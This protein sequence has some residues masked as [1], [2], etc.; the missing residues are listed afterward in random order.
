[1]NNN[2]LIA[3]V[4]RLK[5]PLPEIAKELSIP[6][7]TL[8]KF[9]SGKKE[10]GL[11]EFDRVLEWVEHKELVN[12]FEK[13]LQDEYDKNKKWS[14]GQTAENLIIFGQ[15]VTHEPSGITS[16]TLEECMEKVEELSATIDFRPTDKSAYDGDKLNTILDEHPLYF[17]P[18]KPWIKKIESFCH[19]NKITPEELIM[20]YVA[21]LVK[22]IPRS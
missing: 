15:S 19:E 11:L 14:L 4:N 18:P 21:P 2:E 13:T 16:V 6:T 5:I 1:M 3:A 10:L 8:N 22:P 9:L 12:G 7:A 17:T 20:G